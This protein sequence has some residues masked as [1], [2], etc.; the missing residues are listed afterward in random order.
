MISVIRV[1]FLLAK[2]ATEKK[3]V[4]DFLLKTSKKQ[5]RRNVEE[6]RACVF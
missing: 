3:K 6:T 2:R 5:E 1:T 4:L